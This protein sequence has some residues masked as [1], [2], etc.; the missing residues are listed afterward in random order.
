MS[1][2]VKFYLALFMPELAKVIAMHNIIAA[3]RMWAQ[4]FRLGC[5]ILDQVRTIKVLCFLHPFRL[6]Q[7]WHRAY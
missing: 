3:E 6:P 1:R 2:Y 7:S 4:P 5:V